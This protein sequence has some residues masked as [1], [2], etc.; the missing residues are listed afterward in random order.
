MKISTKFFAAA[1]VV[2]TACGGGTFALE[3][4]SYDVSGAT[5]ASASDQCGLL[6]A[7]VGPPT[8]VIGITTVGTTD[9]ESRTATFNLSNVAGAAANSMPTATLD[10]ENILT[11]LAEANYTSAVE[12]TSCVTRIHRDVI[13]EVTGE[14]IAALTLS[15]TVATETGNC[16]G[17]GI[18]FTA[19]PCASSYQFTATKQE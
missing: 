14:N 11:L 5:L 6:G 7:Y 4:G 13:G 8:K 15:F 2:L 18:P 17:A 3:S 10:K 16:S 9:D 12:G 19:V 1:F